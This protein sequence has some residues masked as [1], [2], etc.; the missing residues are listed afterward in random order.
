[1]IVP[2]LADLMRDWAETTEHYSI[3]TDTDT[4]SF[5]AVLRCRHCYTFLAFIYPT[6]VEIRLD[7]KIPAADPEFFEKIDIDLNSH[8]RCIHFCNGGL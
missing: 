4:G 1:M 3:G 8:Y 7:T 6:Y 5:L 2:S